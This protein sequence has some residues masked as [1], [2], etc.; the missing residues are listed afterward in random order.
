M[1]IPLRGNDNRASANDNFRFAENEG[2]F[3]PRRKFSFLLLKRLSLTLCYNFVFGSQQTSSYRHRAARGTTRAARDPSSPRG[4][5]AL[6]R[7]TSMGGNFPFLFLRFLDLILCER[8]SPHSPLLAVPFPRWGTLR[9][10]P[11]FLC[12]SA[13]IV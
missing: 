11:K 6:L 8:C 13:N 9:A 12:N 10:Y 4:L 7:M 3:P 2:E 1:I 5:R